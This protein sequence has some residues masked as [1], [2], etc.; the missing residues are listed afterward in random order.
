MGDHVIEILSQSDR[1]VILVFRD[2]AFLR[3]SDDF[4]P[5]GGEGMPNTGGLTI[6]DQYA[7]M[8]RKR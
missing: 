8:S 1:S 4:T 6:F 2:Q 7:P 3:K 5:N